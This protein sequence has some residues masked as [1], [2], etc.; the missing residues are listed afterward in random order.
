MN[1]NDDRTDETSMSTATKA[2]LP[3]AGALG[4]AAIVLMGVVGFGVGW[5]MKSSEA[6]E[7]ARAPTAAELD[8]AC[9]PE[10]AV[11]EDE[12][13]TV[14]ARVADLERSEADKARELAEL[15]AKMSRGSNF[16]GPSRA[17]LHREIDALK[18]ELTETKEQLKI[19]EAEK[20]RLL[21]D[22]RQTKE[23]LAS[24]QENLV[25]AVEQ[26]DEAREDAL[27]N[28]WTDFLSDAQL[29]VC[30]KGNRKKLGNCRESVV[31]V[32]AGDA[33]R[34]RYAHCIRS[35]QA[36]PR[37]HEL[38][39]DMELPQYSQMMGEEIKQVRGWFVE[40]CDPTL[41]ERDDISLADGR[42]PPKADKAG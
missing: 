2:A 23:E 28:R 1:D 11:V 7:V 37:V 9:E 31:A 36:E 29:E 16:T 13:T 10:V 21:V 18:T 20:E 39:K 34:D 41:P 12:L 30:D 14:Q 24:T 38:E 32:L 26:R 42:I 19:A 27:Y 35:G 6:L 33:R 3:A 15:K 17:A 5:L 8:E 40:F 4:L 25:V 22:L